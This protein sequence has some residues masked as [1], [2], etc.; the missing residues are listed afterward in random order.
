MKKIEIGMKVRV[1]DPVDQFYGQIGIVDKVGASLVRATDI[2]GAW[3][4]TLKERCI[5]DIPVITED[6]F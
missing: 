5:P 4:I 2:D 3:F 1:V 6:P